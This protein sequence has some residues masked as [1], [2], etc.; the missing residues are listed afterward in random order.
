V[1]DAAGYHGWGIRLSERFWAGDFSTGLD[2]LTG[3]DFI[4]FLTGVVYTTIGQARLGGFLFFSWLG[5]WGLYFSYRAFV[6]A[7]PTGRHRQYAILVLFLPSL[8]FWPSSIGK[9]AWMMFSLGLAAYGIANVL[10]GKMWRG[11]AIAGVGIWCG[12]LVRPHVAGLMGLA[13]VAGLGARKLPEEWRHLAPIAKATIFGMVVLGALLLVD[14]TDDFL[15]DASIRTERGVGS[16]LEQV[17]ERT[18]KGGSSFAPSILESPLRAPIAVPTVLFRPLFFEAHNLQALLAA[19]EGTFL[20]L[21]ALTRVP[22]VLSALRSIRRQPYV[23]FAMAYVILFV[24]AFSGVANFGLLARERVQLLPFFL[25]LLCIP[26]SQES[27]AVGIQS[28]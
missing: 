24:V 14:R 9:E 12:V 15:R 16:V 11:F 6:M 2:S 4:R 22:W 26:P 19:V 27:D 7:C 18:D 13:L 17:S 3:T 8:V 1:A 21:F 10:S 5:F 25:V 20:A 23:A 28:K